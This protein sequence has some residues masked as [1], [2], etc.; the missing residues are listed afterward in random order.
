MRAIALILAVLNVAAMPRTPPATTSY[1]ITG[2][3][4]EDWDVASSAPP[5]LLQ[6]SD[7]VDWDSSG[8]DTVPEGPRRPMDVLVDRNVRHMNIID[9]DTIIDA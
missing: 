3:G 8:Y 5:E 4:N 7:D 2:S 1:D 6:V 9:P